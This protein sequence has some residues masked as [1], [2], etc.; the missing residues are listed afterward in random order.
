[1][2]VIPRIEICGGIASGKTTL[3][4]L[5][6]RLEF[7]PT[8]EDFQ[9]N[10]FWQAFYADPAA[11]AFETE[12]SFLLQHYHDVKAALKAGHPFVC[13]FSPYLDLAYAYVMLSESKRRAFLSVYEEVKRELPPPTL[14]I[15]LQ[16][17][18]ETELGRIR[19]R[20]RRVE[21][22]ITVDYLQQIN[23][24]LEQIVVGDV[25]VRR[26]VLDSEFLDFANS[27]ETKQSVLNTI[28]KTLESA[29]IRI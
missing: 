21:S 1:M 8:L 19:R 15:Y 10:P 22:S 11:N 17:G 6:A 24:R 27:E 16:C 5:L 25:S 12:I 29:A 4:Q 28:S 9:G 7:V 20:G 14:L 3:A 23:S 2:R 18:A 26:L 13:D